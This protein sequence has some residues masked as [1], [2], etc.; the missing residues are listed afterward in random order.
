MIDVGWL[1]AIVAVA[2]PWS[3]DRSLTRRWDIGRPSWATCGATFE[4]RTITWTQ[5]DHVADAG[6]GNPQPNEASSRGL[7]W[8]APPRYIR[9]EFGPDPRCTLAYF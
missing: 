3:A 4:G 1:T 5:P 9:A 6:S 2:F 8:L 7:C